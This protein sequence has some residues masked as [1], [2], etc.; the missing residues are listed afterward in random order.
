M[1]R[2]GVDVGGTNT[3]GVLIDVTCLHEPSR[4]VLA[5]YKAPTTPDVSDGIEAA[6]REVLHRAKVHPERVSCLSIGTTAF[7]NAVLEADARRLAKVAVIRLCGPYTKQ[8]PPFIDFPPRLRALTEGHAGYVDGGFEI[9]GREIAPIKKEQILEQCAIIRSK[10]LKNVVLCGIYSP[11]DNDGKQEVAA[12]QIV[13]RELGPSVNV[14]CSRDVGQV[15]FLERENA[16]ILNASILIFAQRTIRSFQ[17]AMHA[18]N[19]SCPL[20][21]TQNDG[22]LTTAASAARL[23]IRTFASGP[24]NSMRGAAFLAGLDEHKT[25]QQRKS[26]IVAD[27]GGTT[28]DVGV[29]LPSG[30]P[31]Q[32]AA[33]IEVGGVRT[34]FAMADVQSIGLGGGSRVK[35]H[36][37]PKGK[38]VSV[39]P[40]SVGHYLTR[41]SRV[42]G[43]DVLTATDI[44][45]ASGRADVGSKE[46]VAGTGGEVIQKA[47]RII[48]KH[49]EGIIDKMKTSP[50]DIIVLLVGGGSIIAPD[51]LSGVGEILRPPYFIAGEIDT[52]ELLQN[53]NIHDVIEGIKAQAIEKAIAAGADPATTKI[54]EVVNLPV[55]YVTNQATRIIVKAAGDLAPEA[56]ASVNA[57]N[58]VLD[59]SNVH[60]PTEG[61]KAVLPDDTDEQ[62]IDIESYKPT[63]RTDRSWSLT[64]LDLEWIAEGC[65]VMGTGGGGSTYPPFLMARQLLRDGKEIIVVD[66]DDVAE[67][68]VFLRCMFMGAPSVSLERLQGESEIPASIYALTTYMGLKDFKGVVSDEIGGGNGL[69]PMI[70]AAEMGKTVLD[71][72]L[73]GR[74]YPNMYQSLPGAFNIPG[75][76]WPCAVADGIGNT[77]V[78]P[79]AS[80]PKSVETILRTVATEMGSKAGVSMAPLTRSNC[81]KY[82]VSRSVSQAWHIGRAVALCRKKNDLKGI[83]AAILELQN[84]ACLFIGKIVDVQ[85]EVRKGFTWGSVTIVPLLEDEEEDSGDATSAPVAYAYRPE[86]RLIIPFQN[87]N[88]YAYVES[89]NGDKKILVTVPDLITVVDS[90]NGAALGTPDYRYGLR[91]TVIA[92]AAEPKWTTTPEGLACGGPSAFGL[93]DLP[94]TPIAQYKE[95]S[96]VVAQ[97]LSQ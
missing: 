7:I 76:L 47:T 94:F 53:R 58:G 31:R 70:V 79:T 34:N 37:T 36:E 33:F 6:V 3:D 22:T 9:D 46:Q 74:A 23:P 62:E 55:Q 81:Q 71:A 44:V 11:L 5:F 95:P 4:G 2:I 63:I 54:V 48:K 56:V 41:D 68:A 8:C 91:V 12:M 86:D 38:H 42:F 84:G 1:L 17:T 73:M 83:P 80:S 67:D 26:T 14:V 87:E 65:G 43:G 88:L 19:L 82:G 90:Q 18:L 96:G 21:L 30:F 89:P 29:L 57:P 50:E 20:F 39:G 72:D 35:V 52:I 75:G 60:E 13:Q 10:G 40:D 61:E 97:F 64:E 77:V 49:L 78:M 25:A 15:G 51:E 28:T 92:M 66:P 85:R 27:I 16:S 69:Q 93:Y 32:A 45:V 24:T 59:L